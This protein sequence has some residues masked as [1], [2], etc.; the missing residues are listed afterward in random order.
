MLNGEKEETMVHKSRYAGYVLRSSL[1]ALVLL[2][3]NLTGTF[4]DLIGVVTRVLGGA[5]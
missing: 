3:L 2:E 5:P 1:V 4:R